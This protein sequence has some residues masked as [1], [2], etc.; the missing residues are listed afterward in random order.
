M[1]KV[2]EAVERLFGKAP[3]KDVN[4]DEA[5]AAGAAV[6]GSVLS[7]DR[8]D[9]LLLDV[10]PL[11]L[12]IET[13]GGV[14]TKLVQKNTTIPTKASQVFSTA[15]DNQPAVTIKV[16]QGE[17]E[18]VKYNKALGE[19]NLEGI[20][21]ARRGQPQIEVTFDI[22][23]NGIMHI[24]AKDKGTGKENKI[25][26]KSNSGLSEAEIEKMIKDAEANAESD[27]QQRELIETRN[28]A[29]SAVHEIKRE[30]A[31]STVSEDV[32]STVNDAVV[33]VEAAMVSEDV[34][35]IKQSVERLM[36]AARPV[37]EAKSTQQSQ[38]SS[39]ADDNVVD[40]EFTETK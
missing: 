35:Q 17:R 3:R 2:Q 40:A 4:P 22:D 11:S 19:F 5:V 1:P 37:M 9:V 32:K 13:Q 28:Q 34:D 27:K 30:L 23:A 21:P 38:Q 26:I 8:K 31:E 20:A 14:M 12:G 6:Q 39:P 33:A 24:S 18:L 25:T 36:E 15:E 29:E 10:T 7:G 16:A